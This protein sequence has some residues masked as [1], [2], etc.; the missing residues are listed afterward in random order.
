VQVVSINQAPAFPFPDR[1]S[2]GYVHCGTKEWMLF[3]GVD[4]YDPMNTG[5]V[6][7][8][9]WLSDERYFAIWRTALGDANA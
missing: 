5:Q 3:T 4:E 8:G 2:T 6:K 1:I 7:L 9:R